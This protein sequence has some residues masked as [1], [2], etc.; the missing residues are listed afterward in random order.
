[1]E[2]SIW[3]G[4]NHRASGGRISVTIERRDD[5]LKCSIWD[6]G[7]KSD[8][9]EPYDLA[10]YVKRSSRGMSL[11]QGRLNMINELYKTNSGFIVERQSDGT[12]E[13]TRITLTL[14]YDD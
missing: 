4:L 11:I 6:N 1:V 5:M 10:Q 3:H 12:E 9:Q 8:T 7:V 13:G 14:P 2:N